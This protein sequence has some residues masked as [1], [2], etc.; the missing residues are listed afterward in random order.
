MV[1]D[2]F[3]SLDQLEHIRPLWKEL[4]ERDTA[5]NLFLSWEWLAACLSAEALPWVILGVRDGDGPYLAFLPLR[6][7]QFPERGP[8]L[9]RDLSLGLSPHADFTGMLGVGGEESRFIPALAHKIE[10]LGWDNFRLN[11][12][13]D[14]RITALVQRFTSSRY[15]IASGSPT[16]CPY[17]RLPSTWE[18]YLDSR[19]RSTRRTIRSHLR[20]LESLPGYRFHVASLDEATNAIDVL[21]RLHSLRWKK[22]FERRRSIIGELL[23]RCYQSERFQVCAMYDG[24]T[25]VAT[26]GFFFDRNRRTIVAYMIAHNPDYAQYSPG[27][28]LG[29]VS[30]RRAIE[31]GYESFNFSHGA[32]DYKMSLATGVEYIS[33]TT[34][35]RRNARVAVVHAGT[36]A[37]SA[38]KRLARNF[39][40]RRA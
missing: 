20:K 12:Y 16:P 14:S 13:A 30:V 22:D 36:T 15:R 28:M 11:N 6:L 40:A 35:S 25:L 8:A 5:A 29:C 32:Q 31:E 38:A 2:R 19:G 23:G 33:N 34:V 24:S 39:L 37:V 4:Y 27:V 3:S 10:G 7:S 9:T 26:Q 18:E 21:L 1:V 17:V